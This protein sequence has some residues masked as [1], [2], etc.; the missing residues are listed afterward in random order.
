C[1]MIISDF[2]EKTMQ[3]RAT[4]SASDP[5]KAF[6]LRAQIREELIGYLKQNYADLLPRVLINSTE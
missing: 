6:E 5:D 4:M 2:S 1:K 3:V